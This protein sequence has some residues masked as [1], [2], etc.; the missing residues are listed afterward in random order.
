ME[1]GPW[2]EAGAALARVPGECRLLG[3]LGNAGLSVMGNQDL[4][5]H[6]GLLGVTV[7]LPSLLLC[8]AWH[9]DACHHLHCPG[10]WTRRRRGTV[11]TWGGVLWEKSR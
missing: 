10:D 2:E 11:E 1:P 3:T 8:P 4:L 6:L 7:S 9:I 5:M